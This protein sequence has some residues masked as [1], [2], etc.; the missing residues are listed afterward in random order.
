MLRILHDMSEKSHSKKLGWF[1]CWAVVFAD[2]GTSIYYVPGILY[3]QVGHLAGLFVSLTSLAFVLLVLKYIEITDR[4]AEG[5]GVV[6]VATNS[7][8]P[9]F[10]AL[11]GMF[12]TVDYFLTAAISAVSGFQYLATILN[13]APYVVILAALGIIFLGIL[14]TI[15]IKESA[16]VTAVIAVGAFIVD[17]LLVIFVLL[18]LH[19]AAW[20]LLFDSYSQVARLTPW[21]VL[22]GFA[23]SFLAFSG[24][25]SISQLSPAMEIPR[26]KIA[27]IAMVAVIAAIM[28]TSPTL[29]VFSTNVL[30]AKVPEKNETILQSVEQ[31]TARQELL[32]Q[33][34]DPQKRIQLQ[35]QIDEGTAYTGEFISELGAQYGGF[36]LK[37]AV[38]I[39]ASILLLFASNTAIIGAYHVF[40]ALSRQNFLPHGLQNRNARFGTPH[41]AIGLAVI[42]PVIIVFVTNGNLSLLGDLYAFGL[43]GAFGLSSTGLD[44]VRWKENKRGMMFFIGIMTSILVIVAW[45]VNLYSKPLATIFGG[46][47]TVVGMIVAFVM[48]TYFPHKEFIGELILTPLS[49]IK[50]KQIFVPVFG[51]FDPSL[52]TF[53]A[54]QAKGTG[55]QVILMYIRTFPDILQTVSENLKLDEEAE[56]Y[57]AKAKKIME[58]HA[59]SPLITY[60]VNSDIAECINEYRKKLDPSLTILSPHKQSK[61]I[62]FIRGNIVNDVLKYKNGTVLIHTGE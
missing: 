62:E 11:G 25:E 61:L 14:N 41:W 55:K 10:G 60:H 13:I 3:G 6:T 57:L 46:S 44:V 24:L 40:I 30:T 22:T 37:L 51:E 49:R 17:V 29:T 36:I 43:L 15:G 1:L 32:S 27:T 12:I 48:H 9:W 16:S 52:F 39:T 58:K 5:G 59:I 35:H 45:G 47:V 53:A 8:G 31:V 23:G 56:N 2:I 28:I 7:F 42:A 18:Q 50:K 33:T 34:K 20:K 4:Y 26:K 19:P 54:H 38:V 21:A